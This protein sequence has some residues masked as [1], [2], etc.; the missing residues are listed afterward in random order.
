M[1]GRE[2]LFALTLVLLNLR[3]QVA[4]HFVEVE[5]FAQMS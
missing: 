5:K 3:V 2:I 4:L 1:G